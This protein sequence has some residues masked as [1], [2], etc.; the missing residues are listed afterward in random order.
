MLTR[1]ERGKEE[2]EEEVDL[3]LAHVSITNCN[4][5]LGRNNEYLGTSNPHPA[6]HVR[7]HI[8]GSE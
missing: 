3:N 2:E 6:Q 8:T 7:T 4:K 5:E 1:E